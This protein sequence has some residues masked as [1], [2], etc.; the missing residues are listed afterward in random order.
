MNNYCLIST[1]KN[2]VF[3]FKTFINY[4]RSQK[5]LNMQHEEK[6]AYFRFTGCQWPVDD[7]VLKRG[8]SRLSYP[9]RSPACALH[10]EKPSGRNRNTCIEIQ[11]SVQLFQ[12]INLKHKSQK[13]ACREIINFPVIN[14]GF[15]EKETRAILLPLMNT[16]FRINY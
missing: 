6:L 10:Q 7:K 3:V 5:S 8:R 14:S 13:Q 9:G 16:L 11:H 1:L 4:N 15:A 2:W 12:Q